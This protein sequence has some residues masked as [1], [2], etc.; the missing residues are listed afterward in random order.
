M[1][2]VKTF[3]ALMLLISL[4]V[5]STGCPSGLTSA[6]QSETSASSVTTTSDT[7]ETTLTPT[8]KPAIYLYPTEKTDV[9]VSLLYNGRLTCT[10]PAYDGL[11][12]VTAFPGGKLI[13]QA[14]GREYAYLYWEGLTDVKY[15]LSRGFVVRGEDT[16]GFLQ[17]KLALLGLTPKEYNEFI[18][19]WLPQM[20]D[21]PYN[22]ITFQQD[23]YTANA[24][25]KITPE[26]D[27]MLRVF[28][29][30]KPLPEFIE[31][32]APILTG[33]QREGFTVV[34]WGGS[35]IK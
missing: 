35:C 22:L 33:F 3:L 17:E 5:L 24:I 1:R 2:P 23:C 26:P 13:N 32:P 15:D 7:S 25:L 6:S 28:M 14:D 21:N 4:A 16:A 34:E 10:Y 31:I 18:V 29:V 27:S 9:S 11:W 19:F 8:R 20:Q 12:R 30:Y